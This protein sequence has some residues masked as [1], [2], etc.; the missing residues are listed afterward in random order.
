MH[1]WQLGPLLLPA[2][3]IAAQEDATSGVKNGGR[4]TSQLNIASLPLP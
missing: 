3:I 4:R 2:Q 1:P